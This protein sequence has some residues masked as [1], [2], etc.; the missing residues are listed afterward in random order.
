MLLQANEAS[1]IVL[2][3][4]LFDAFAGCPHAS[5]HFLSKKAKQAFLFAVCSWF[6]WHLAARTRRR[7]PFQADSHV[8][9]EELISPDIAAE[10]MCH[11]RR[12]TLMCHIFRNTSVRVF[13]L[14][15]G[16]VCC[17]YG[18]DGLF[19]RPCPGHHRHSTQHSLTF[20]SAPPSSSGINLITHCTPS[21]PSKL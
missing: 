2:P 19:I 7:Y 14:D 10:E 21:P 8:A 12:A 9:L 15:C 18:F 1:F 6:L 4:C 17:L 11:H 20:L 13:L 3:Q 16:I 5:H